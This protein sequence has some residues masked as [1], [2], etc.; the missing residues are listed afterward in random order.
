MLRPN[1]L[2]QP[3]RRRDI[4]RTAIAAGLALTLV[5]CGGET[6]T[7]GSSGTATAAAPGAPTS[8]RRPGGPPDGIGAIG[9]LTAKVTA[10]D[11]VDRFTALATATAAESID[12]T[13]RISSVVTRINFREGQEVKAGQ[14]LVELDSL[15]I[16]ADLALA[17]ASL[18]QARSQFERSRSLASARIISETQ[19]EE[20][21]AKM[22][23]ADAQVRSAQARLD[24][25]F[26]RAPFTGTIGLRRVS[27][28][29]L[30]GSDSVITTLDDTRTIRLEFKVPETFLGTL[31]IGMT[32]DATSTV[33]PGRPFAGTIASIDSRVDPVTRAVTV[34]ATVPNADRLLKPGMFLTANLER[35]R[36][37]V[38][39]VPEEAL[40]P[41]QGRQFV[42]LVQDGRAVEREVEIGSRSP[43]LAEVRNGLVA[44]DTVVTEGTQRLRD[45]MPVQLLSSS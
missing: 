16:R 42:F 35:A 21:E 43:G 26:I 40:T 29:D 7:D 22:K 12:V 4:R 5:A 24:H 18:Q 8:E 36:K 14:L 45:G 19:M 17:E 33:Y 27:P 25:A 41:R 37:D 30:V 2:C 31:G 6:P 20:L 44:G 38:L 10:Q 11:F 39:L 28:G 3:C 13:S 1:L 15:E 34:I 23:M 9:V 32:I